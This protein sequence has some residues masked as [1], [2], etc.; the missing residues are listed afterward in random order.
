[1]N[2]LNLKSV[3]EA[4]SYQV[5]QENFSRAVAA[6]AARLRTEQNQ[7]F[8]QRLFNKLPFT[9]PINWR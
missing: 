2:Q 1:M 6:Y 3:Q 5:H 7:S 9:I 4:A 8:W